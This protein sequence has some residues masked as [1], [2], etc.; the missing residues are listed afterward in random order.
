MIR[1]AL[2]AVARNE[3]LGGIIGRAPL[4]R[5]VV[6]R[7]VGGE[8]VDSALVVATGLADR[9]LFVSLERAAGPLPDD[10]GAD[11]VAEEY[12]S[13]VDAIAEAGLAGVCEV[14]VLPE[15]LG[16]APGL[17]PDAARSRFTR[18]AEV[19]AERSVAVMLG[20]GPGT[21]TAQSLDWA[22]LA[23]ADGLGV[24][25]TLPAALRRTEA[26]CARLAGRRVRLVKGVRSGDPAVAFG[27]PIEIDKAFVRCAKALLRGEG[28]ASFATHDP[29]LLDIVQSLVGRYG[30]P[31]QSY[32]FVFF[33]GRLEGAQ[34]RLLAESER[35][36]VYVP[37]GPDWFERLVAGLAEQ[38][39]TVTAAL[40]SMLPG[41]D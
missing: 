33:M 1:E 26:D 15:A 29:R 8:T 18:I 12:G 20:M 2:A 40:R 32:E 25:V 35:V 16:L 9:G 31:R 24:G 10:D 3:S 7:V 17:D 38:P 19:A 6:K 14:T 41:S 11:A 23:A 22:D 21:D 36:R 39:S 37:Y 13:L 30:R 34:D 4:A 5:D 27:Q 28:E